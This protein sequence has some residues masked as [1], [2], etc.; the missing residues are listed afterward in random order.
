MFDKREI[1]LKNLPAP[2]YYNNKFCLD[3]QSVK[4]SRLLIYNMNKY[5]C[6]K[7]YG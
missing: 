2:C 6:F 5:C 7:T 3:L 1:F 4:L